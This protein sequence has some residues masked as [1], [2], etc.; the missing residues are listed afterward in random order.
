MTPAD[1]FGNICFVSGAMLGLQPEAKAAEKK[2][3]PEKKEDAKKKKKA[4]NK[5]KK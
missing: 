4:K 2:V 5:K 3:A 1:R